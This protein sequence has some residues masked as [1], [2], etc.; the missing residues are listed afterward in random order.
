MPIRNHKQ[1]PWHILSIFMALV[2]GLS[3]VISIR[4]AVAVETRDVPWP[5]AL[6]NRATEVSFPPFRFAVSQKPS[7]VGGGGNM[8]VLAWGQTALVVY[9]FT[10][11]DLPED[12]RQQSASLVRNLPAL[13]FANQDNIDDPLWPMVEILR[14]FYFQGASIA[15]HARRNRLHIYYSNSRFHEDFSG[16]AIIVIDNPEATDHFLRIDAK[17]MSFE[18]FESILGTF[19]SHLE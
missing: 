16:S 18:Q 8:L 9:P 14:P 19:T 3:S 12:L 17:N 15:R 4:D 13:L 10:R 5:R 11:Q 2:T 6:E 1:I 7:R